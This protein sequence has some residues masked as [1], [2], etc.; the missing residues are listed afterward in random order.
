MWSGDWWEVENLDRL[1]LIVRELAE[2]ASVEFGGALL[3]P[4]AHSLRSSGKVTPDGESVLAAAKSAGKELIEE[5][6][7]NPDTLKQISRPLISLEE[8][9]K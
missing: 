9:M 4:H 8:Y 7:M 6:K 1:V 3:R 5:G 2:D